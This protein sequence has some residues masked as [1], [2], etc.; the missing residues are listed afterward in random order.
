MAALRSRRGHNFL[1]FLAFLVLSTLLWFVMALND[2]EQCDVRM[3]L[4]L[5]NVPDSVTIISTP[6]Q[7]IAVGL[8]TR[9]SQRLK[10]AWSGAPKINVDFRIYRS[11]NALHLSNTDLKSLA[12][13]AVDGASII[14][15]SPD[16]LNLLFTTGKGTELPVIVDYSVTAGPKSSL[17]GYPL[18]S[19]DSVK[20]Y[21]LEPLTA[22][23]EAVATE[24]FRMTGLNES[25]TR[26]LA[27]VPPPG[28]RVVP[29]S[30][31]VTFNVEPLILKSRMVTV[32]TQHVPEDRRLI[33]FPARVEVI[34]MISLSDFKNNPDPHMKVVADYSTIDHANPTRNIRLKLMDV[35]ANLQN[36][37]LAADSAEYIIEQL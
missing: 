29:D 31:D 37:H 10:L 7:A 30:V 23:I 21:S 15:V 32:E 26:R 34:Y 1:V 20:V 5:T 36:V 17:S 11:G 13:N 19:V 8:R 18:L 24:P 4:V 6:P 2:E 28:T 33:T 35:S 9:G 22:R 25:V 12:R 16:S 27:L 3:P 14:L